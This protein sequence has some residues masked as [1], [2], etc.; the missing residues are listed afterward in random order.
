[1]RGFFLFHHSHGLALLGSSFDLACL[2][3]IKAPKNLV[4]SLKR[5]ALCLW[6]DEIDRNLYKKSVMPVKN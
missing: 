2:D 3:E 6:K 5:Y 1:M 4:H